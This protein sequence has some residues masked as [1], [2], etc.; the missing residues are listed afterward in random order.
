MSTD[1][2]LEIVLSPH[3]RLYVDTPDQ[4][5][6]KSAF[7][8]SNASG[9]LA[10]AGMRNA[11]SA[12]LAFWRE[13]ALAF[14]HTLARTPAS[15]DGRLSEDLDMPLEL[16]AELALRIPAM[17]GAEYASSDALAQ[18]WAELLRQAA[19][20]ASGASGLRA[21]LT[22]INPSL[23]ALGKV[24]FHLAENKRTPDTPF[25]FMATYT[26]RLSAQDKP[27]H[28]PLA[29]AL[30]EYAGAKNQAALRSLLEPVQQ[31]AE[32]SAW[33]REM[34]D[35]RAVFQAQAWDTAEAY[36]FSARDAGAGIQRHYHPHPKLVEERT[37][38]APA[39]ECAHWRQERC[40]ARHR[41]Y[42]H[43]FNRSHA[44]TARSSTQPSGRR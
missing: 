25:A 37:R 6:L 3:G 16:G 2:E 1:R 44:W 34:L 27:V 20:E 8:Q 13:F 12:P 4:T 21:W 41:Q 17:R 32:R 18:L 15:A 42:A 40:G 28:L 38:A 43:L 29:R 30:Q 19:A 14:L 22:Q 31:A 10:L 26:H 23:H 33:A 35:S 24:T 11:L 5:G 39:S 7:E 9:L 36:A